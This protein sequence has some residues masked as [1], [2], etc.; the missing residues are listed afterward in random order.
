MN[1][2][3]R[4]WLDYSLLILLPLPRSLTD[5]RLPATKHALGV[6]VKE[7]LTAALQISRLKDVYLQY[8]ANM[9]TYVVYTIAYTFYM[10]H[11]C[12]RLALDQLL[13][14]G[15]MCDCLVEL[16]VGRSRRLNSADNWLD[17]LTTSWRTLKKELPQTSNQKQPP[18][19]LPC[20]V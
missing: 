7:W 8:E 18:S 19:G 20:E 14:F 15:A 5:D 10:G 13:S 4:D 2:V 17:Q 16:Q 6:F 3:M 11:T 9:L 12:W 1:T